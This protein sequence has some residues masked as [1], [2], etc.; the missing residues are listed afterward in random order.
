MENMLHYRCPNCGGAIEFST[1]DQKLKCPYCDSEFDVQDLEQHEQFLNQQEDT[2]WQTYQQV[3]LTDDLV[4][5]S[6]E[7]CGGAIVCESK[8]A[9]TKCPYCDSPVVLSRKV[10]GILRPEYVLPFQLDKEQAKAAMGQH[11]KGKLL[12]PKEF[13]G[14]HKLEE[15][16]G[17]YVPFWLFDCDADASASFRATR[18]RKW[19]DHNYRYTKTSHFTLLRDGKLRFEKVPVD[20]SKQI[21]DEYMEAIEPYDYSKMLAFEPGYLAGFAAD[22]Y[23]LDSEA[24]MPRANERIKNSAV[25]ELSA[26]AVGYA[27]CVPQDVHLNFR[28]QRT[29]YALLP[30]WMLSTSY[31]GKRYLFAMNGQTGKFVG[32]LPMSKSRFWWLTLI[33]TLA[34]TPLVYLLLILFL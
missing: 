23:D 32:E 12:L 6:C 14:S 17:I 28:N 30:V 4:E 29:H 18:I 9:A 2:S 27:T 21:P 19:S 3:D 15:I 1:R 16:K 20:G 25:D 24:A 5:Y 31:Q 22:R 11:L 33:A 7:N 13:K 10:S 26:T 8:T 34:A